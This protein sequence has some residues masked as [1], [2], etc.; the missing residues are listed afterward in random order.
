MNHTDLAPKDLVCFSH[1]RWGFVFQ[2]PQHLMSRFAKTHRVFFI[3]EPVYEEVAAPVIRMKRCEKTGVRVVTP[4]LPTGTSPADSAQMTE[5][6][7]RKL[8]VENNIGDFIAWYYTPMALN[9]SRTLQPAVCVYDC[10][11]ELSLFRNAPPALR[12]NEQELFER[13]NLVFTGGVSLFEAKRRQHSRVYPFPSSVDCEHFRK[14]RTCGDV[15]EDQ[16]SLPRPRIGYAGVID[17]R[18][19][20]DLIR[21]IAERRPDWHIVM[22]G[23]VVKIDP[24]TL[25]QRDNIH[26]LGMKDY[27]QLPEYMAGWDVAIMPFALN[28]STRYISPT[29]T[30]EY[31]AA[32]LPVVS[33][34]IRDVESQYGDKG[35][36]RIESTV[37]GFLRTV[38]QALMYEMGMKARERVDAYLA[39]LSWD[40]T[41]RAMS[42]LIEQELQPVSTLVKQP[43]KPAVRHAGALSA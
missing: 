19:D 30:P 40:D 41:W 6:L 37:E 20:L 25:P 7:V 43:P 26:W 13:S 16:K 28:D 24:A 22:I 36:V 1:L 5:I 14:A 18:I 8:F 4:V 39:T 32:G 3:E 29:K 23:P 27:S 33:T 9:Y 15:A 34:P 11:D 2:R 31:L 35:L 12:K 38:E 10:M 42:Q 21:A 17:E